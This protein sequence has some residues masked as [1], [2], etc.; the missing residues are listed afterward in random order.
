[1]SKVLDGKLCL[2]AFAVTIRPTPELRKL[3]DPQDLSKD[4]T[5]G[6]SAWL[7]VDDVVDKETLLEFVGVGK[8]KL[9]R[10]P[11][12][13]K[14]YRITGGDPSQ[15]MTPKGELGI[16][17]AV[18]GPVPSHYLRRP[19]GTVNIIYSVP[20]FG[21]GGQGLDSFLVTDG[22]IF[23][24]A[25]GAKVFVQP[26]YYPKGDP[27]KGHVAPKTMTFLYGAAEVKG[28]DPVY[29]WVAKEALVPVR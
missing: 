7:P 28:S 12:E 21:L 25:K 19:S 17:K 29:G 3:L 22:V 2:Y 11:L 13:N 6:T 20:G 27:R 14:T 1:M 8:V 26:T 24:P 16:V 18:N 15:Y 10:L 23:R 9:P 5:V 4:G